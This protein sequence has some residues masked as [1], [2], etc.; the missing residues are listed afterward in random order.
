MVSLVVL[1]FAIVALSALCSGSEAAIVALSPLQARRLAQKGGRRAEALLQLKEN[2]ARPLAAI[3]ILNNVFNIVG[4]MLVG[5]MA[6]SALDVPGWGPILLGLFPIVLTGLI[7]VFAEII[8]KTLGVRY[9]EALALA[10]AV[11]LWWTAWLL[12]PLLRVVEGLTNRLGDDATESTSEG[13]LRFLVRHGGEAGVLEDHEV[14][15]ILR[16]FD[17]N[18]VRADKIM[19]PRTRMTTLSSLKTL[20]EQVDDVR[21]SQHS[22]MVVIGEQ[23]D[24]VIGTVLRDDV[25]LALLDG[26]GDELLTPDNPIVTPPVFV[27]PERSADELFVHFRESRRLLAVVRD[28][29][30]GVGGVVTLEDV[31]E[32]VTGEIVD[33]TD[34]AVDLRREARLRA[35]QADADEAGA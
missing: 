12:T 22:R 14:K 24:D 30:G 2:M 6:A 26:K 25:L 29:F 34:K 3:V 27:P 16:V 1:V 17:L 31:L 13:Q 23:V 15:M 33:E 11:P 35:S 19:T 8:P 20:E 18:D 32:I 21:R 28:E 9:A 10:L 4:S 5:G 7:I